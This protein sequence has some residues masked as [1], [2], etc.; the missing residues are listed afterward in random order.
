MLAQSLESSDT[1]AIVALIIF[2]GFFGFVLLLVFLIDRAAQKHTSRLI[3]RWCTEN[4]F[5]LLSKKLDWLS[6][7]RGPFAFDLSKN[8]P[9][10]A[11][12]VKAQTGE[13]RLRKASI[14]CAKTW[15]GGNSDRIVVVWESLT[16]TNEL[17]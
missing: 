2:L 8:R 12:T 5:E 9:V 16:P 13:L 1:I 17:P 4:N 10:Y 6:S 7:I 11:V 14:A 3:D 15:Y